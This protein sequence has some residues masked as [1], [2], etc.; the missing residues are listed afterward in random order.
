MFHG[1]RYDKETNLYYFRAR[2]Y[3][4]IMGRFLSVDPMGYKDSMNLYQAFNQNPINFVDPFGKVIHEW[5]NL[6]VY[7]PASWRPGEPFPNELPNYNESGAYAKFKDFIKI[8][9]VQRKDGDMD[10]KS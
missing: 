1:R 9:P 5:K 4:P 8:E 2:Y 3:D 7:G 6:G 10:Y